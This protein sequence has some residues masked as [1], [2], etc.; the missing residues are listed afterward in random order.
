MGYTIYISPHHRATKPDAKP[1]KTE[2]NFSKKGECKAAGVRGRLPWEEPQKVAALCIWAHLWLYELALHVTPCV[3]L[4][5][6][7]LWVSMAK[8]RWGCWCEHSGLWTLLLSRRV[9]KGMLPRE[10]SDSTG[11]LP[12]LHINCYLMALPFFILAPASNELVKRP[13]VRKDE[14]WRLRKRDR[15]VLPSLSPAWLGRKGEGTRSPLPW[16]HL[17][18]CPKEREGNIFVTVWNRWETKQE[19]MWNA[20][21]SLWEVTHN[22]ICSALHTQGK[23]FIQTETKNKDEP[24][25]PSGVRIVTTSATQNQRSLQTAGG[26]ACMISRHMH[27]HTCTHTHI[28]AHAHC[29]LPGPSS[30]ILH[31]SI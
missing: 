15:A 9:P 23:F 3:T 11:Y 21:P 10:H 27:T 4:A 30:S 5:S 31:P 26:M 25:A 12:H 6:V 19:S 1:E 22:S 16:G 20:P 13:S 28:H 14:A 7:S 2:Q 8:G 17:S 29:W 24:G 18:P